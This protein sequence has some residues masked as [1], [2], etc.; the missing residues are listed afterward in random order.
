MATPRETFAAQLQRDHPDFKVLAYPYTPANV[1]DGKPVVSVWRTDIAP[2][3]NRLALTHSLQV[4]AYGARTVTAAAEDEMDNL[5][6]AVLLTVAGMTGWTFTTA[7]RTTWLE[8]KLSGW[9][10]TLKAESPNV[11]REITLEKG[12]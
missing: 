2:G 7:T 8:G 9:E 12:K 5:I 1:E 11:Y 4:N 10:I 6:D 3:Q